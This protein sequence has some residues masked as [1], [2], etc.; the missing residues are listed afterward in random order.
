M[1]AK[2][3]FTKHEKDLLREYRQKMSA[4]E[5]TEDVKKFYLRTI[6]ELFER[7][8]GDQVNLEYE[9]LRWDETRDAALEFRADVEDN[10]RFREV[11]DNSD[12]PDIVK[13]FAETAKNRYIHLSKHPDRTEAKMF[14]LHDKPDREAG[15]GH[16][17]AR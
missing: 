8:F 5:S 11:W 7:V 13:R 10:P 15:P 9:D 12:L 3:S 2:R 16:G 6:L 1:T 14:N 4:A 17:G